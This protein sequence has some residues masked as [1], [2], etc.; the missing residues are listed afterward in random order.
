VSEYQGLIHTWLGIA[1]AAVPGGLWH[2][3]LFHRATGWMRWMYLHPG[4]CSTDEYWALI[5]RRRSHAYRALLKGLLGGFALF[6][7]VALR[8]TP[9]E[10]LIIDWQSWVAVGLIA[11]VVWL[12][13]LWSVQ[14]WRTSQ[15]WIGE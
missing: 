8:R 9:E 14:D 12:L 3:W 13:T 1:L 10:D 2:L 5:V 15:H 11:A 6:V 4:R 7:Y